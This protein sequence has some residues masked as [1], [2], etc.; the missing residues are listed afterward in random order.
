MIQVVQVVRNQVSHEVA[1][2]GE[3][4]DIPAGAERPNIYFILAD[5]HGRQDIL[6][7]RYGY[8]SRAVR[9]ST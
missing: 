8:S 7:E 2:L 4:W 1:P 3:G 9:G 5:G 6:A